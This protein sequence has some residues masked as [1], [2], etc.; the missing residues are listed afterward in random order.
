MNAGTDG[1]GANYTE[2][3]GN[4]HRML[5]AVATVGGRY[6]P[7]A[8]LATVVDQ[9]LTALEGSDLHQQIMA[10]G[11]GGPLDTANQIASV[12][13]S[14]AGDG[15]GYGGDGN[16]DS[17]P[18]APD[19]TCFPKGTLVATTRGLME[20]ET[21]KAGDEVWAYDVVESRWFPRHVLKTFVRLYKGTSVSI[22]VG[23]ETIVSTFRHPYWV[24][25]GHNLENRPRLP[26][27]HDVPR[28]ATTPGR[29]VDAG[30]VRVGDELLLRDGRILEVAEIRHEPYFDEVYNFRV[31]Q[32]ECYAV[33]RNSI[34]VHNDNGD[35]AS[36]VP[37]GQGGGFGTPGFGTQ[38]HQGFGDA[39]SQQTNTL[40]Q[41]WTM[42]TGPGQNG[43]DATFNGDVTSPNYPGFQYAELK[44]ATMS[45]FNTFMNQMG[46]W[47]LSDG[48]TQLWMYD[49]NG[50]IFSTGFNFIFEND[51][52]TLQ[53]S[54]D[55]T[56][57]ATNGQ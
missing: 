48:S 34:L 56:T 20:I 49:Q 37:D 33:G 22:I 35:Q 9:T 2:N 25:R 39:L 53:Q 38:V 10:R 52:I 41:D 46:N 43:V 3:A 19:G 21:I 15:G 23:D 36:T 45:G 29:W 7:L 8:K 11:A 1:G 51:T 27:L 12:V 44:P 14:V 55:I 16:P 13:V 47:Q 26:H 31:D 18:S 30:D 6:T 54:A 17:N 28:D 32:L 42:A 5:Q 57:E 50:N 40:P 24:V 4:A